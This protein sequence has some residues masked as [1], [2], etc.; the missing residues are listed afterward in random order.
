MPAPSTKSTILSLEEVAAAAVRWCGGGFLLLAA[1]RLYFEKKKR[2]FFLRMFVCSEAN[3][4]KNYLEVSVVA[5]TVSNVMYHPP[6]WM[7]R[8]NNLRRYY[9]GP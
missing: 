7:A 4:E 6:L 1:L 3:A 5:T 9:G 8:P 2:F